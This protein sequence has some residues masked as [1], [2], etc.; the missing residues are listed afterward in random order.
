[1]FFNIFRSSIGKKTVMAVTGLGLLGFVIVH[2]LGNLQIF[3]GPA[4]LNGY[5]EHLED[6]PFLLIPARIVLASMLLVHMATA[7]VLT[8]QN[9]RARPVPYSA[10]D[11]V[12][13]T[14]ASRTMI[15]TGSAVLLFIIYHLLHYTWGI[16]HPQYFHFEDSEGHHDVYSMVVLSF[17]DIKISATYLLALLVLSVHLGHG[18]SSF[19]QSLGLTPSGATKKIRKIGTALGWLIFAGY[20]SIPVAV[21]S[22]LLKPGGG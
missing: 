16:A 6:L 22:G 9:K 12:Q 19:L 11:T 20:A 4:W 14:L 17:Q 2:L 3:L 18:L 5:S 21:L 15:F 13:A 7:M 10:E 8:V 1:M